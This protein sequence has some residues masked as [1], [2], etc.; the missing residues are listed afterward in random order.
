MRTAALVGQDL[1]LTGAKS[2]WEFFEQEETEVTEKYPSVISV[3]SCSKM[4]A[5]RHRPHEMQAGESRL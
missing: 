5:R 4:I 2:I 3:S 1:R